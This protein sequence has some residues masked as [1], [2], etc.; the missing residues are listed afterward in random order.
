MDD[1]TI[2]LMAIAE[3]RRRVAVNGSLLSWSQIAP[4]FRVGDEDVLFATRAKGIF[5]PR[6]MERGALSIRSPVPRAGRLRR[7]VD[8]IEGGAIYYSFQGTNP[9]SGDNQRLRE[10]YEDKVPL[11]YFWGVSESMY[12]AVFPVFISRW[13]PEQLRVEISVEPAPRK[14]E[15]SALLQE[16]QRRY[17]IREVQ[18][19][20]HQSAFREMVLN[21]YRGRCAL[22]ALPVRSLLTAAHIY[23]DI[24]ELG[25]AHVTNGIALTTLHHTAYDARLIGISPDYRVEVSSR[26]FSETDGPLL[27]G[28]KN[29]H[30]IKMRL[31]REETLRPDR[32]ALAFRFEKFRIAG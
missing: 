6:A 13:L 9:A 23:P 24:H 18:E 31:P 28:L 26:I 22:S 32:D 19:R 10:A 7:Y 17:R 14:G 29:L 1:S 2:R 21:A 5:K 16:E 3:L 30:G 25:R 20:V 11:I 12:E 15:S 4:T 8:P 27:E